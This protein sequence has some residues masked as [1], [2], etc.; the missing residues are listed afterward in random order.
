ME[1]AKLVVLGSI[2]ADHILN[3]NQFPQPGETV[4]GQ[5]YKVAF[6]GKGANQAVAAGRSGADIA[7]IACVG[8]DDIGERIRQ[9][10][11]TDRIDTQ[12]IEAIA[13]STTGVALIFVNAEGENVIGID[14]GAN[15][16]VTPDYLNRYRQRVI[17]ADALLMQLE[18]PLETVIAAAK[19]AKQHQTQVILNPAPACELPDEL[20]A[21]IDMITPNETE[22][23]RLTGIAVNNDADAERAAN[24]LHDKGIGCVII[25]LGSR[26]VWLS[27]NGKGKLVPGFKVK[28]VDTIAAGDTFNGALVTALLEGKVMSDAVRFAHAAAAIAVTR[29]GA[30]PSVPWREEIDAFLQ[31][32]G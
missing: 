1:T 21:M 5:Q 6:G 10:L 19:L 16:A 17:D 30:Q 28:A 32:Q 14:A 2:N 4:I 31:Q 18:S 22:A 27:E 13:D 7:F 23:Q 15:A 25:T 26:G 20:L 3:I 8:A 11:A 24:I 29:P 12:P 9:Q